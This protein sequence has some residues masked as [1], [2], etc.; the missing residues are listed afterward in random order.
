MAI[1]YVDYIY[2]YIYIYM[3]THT[4]VVCW[5]DATVALTDMPADASVSSGEMA[6][7]KCAFSIILLP[8]SSP[9]DVRL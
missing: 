6:G 8:C 1:Q 5:S 4:Q 2:I 9:A 7:C 3:S